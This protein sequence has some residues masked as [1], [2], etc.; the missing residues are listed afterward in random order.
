M[1]IAIEVVKE[2]VNTFYQAGVMLIYIGAW[3]VWL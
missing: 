2:A 3:V 1:E